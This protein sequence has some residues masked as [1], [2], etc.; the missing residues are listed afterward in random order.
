[1]RK[2]LLMG[3]G[4]T[5]LTAGVHAQDGVLDPAF[6]DNGVVILEQNY[7]DTVELRTI[8]DE[9]H[10]VVVL[11]DNWVDNSLQFTRYLEDGTIDPSFGTGGVFELATDTLVD[12]YSMVFQEDGKLLVV[13]YCQRYAG[14]D[15]F[16]ARLMP[17]GGVDPSFGNAGLVSIDLGQDEYA[18][19]V[20][21]LGSGEILVCGSTGVVSWVG[22]NTDVVLLRLLPNGQLDPAFGVDGI[23]ITDLTITDFDIDRGEQIAVQPDGKVVVAGVNG[24]WANGIGDLAMLRYEADGTLDDTFGSG[25]IIITPANIPRVN[26]LLIRDGGSLLI[27]GGGGDVFSGGFYATLHQYMSAGSLDAAFADNGMY[28]SQPHPNGRGFNV[29]AEQNDHRILAAGHWYVQ[30]DEHGNGLLTRFTEQGELDPSFGTSG[31]A[32]WSMGN[33]GSSHNEVYRYPTGRITVVGTFSNQTDTNMVYI[34]RYLNESDV[35]TGDLDGIG[36]TEA[37]VFPDPV[38]GD[39]ITLVYTLASPDRVRRVLIDAEGRCI[40]VLGTVERRSVGRQEEM[41]DLPAGLSPGMYCIRL[42]TSTGVQLARFI[43]LGE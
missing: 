36:R 38:S 37:K 35:S 34:A 24:T 9:Q 4:L 21:V 43:K 8:M 31:M 28:A 30:A 17:D 20:A 2:L 7:P 25:G 27:A 32:L 15:M 29:V 6:G 13:G 18:N 11:A 12:A 42:E 10:R 3:I 22:G 41:V 26:D 1:M 33:C 16:I 40:A 14:D 39:R 23:T 5:L 19:D